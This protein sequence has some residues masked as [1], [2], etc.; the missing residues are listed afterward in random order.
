MIRSHYAD[1]DYHSHLLIQ[2]LHDIGRAT[3]ENNFLKQTTDCHVIS[4]VEETTT[5]WSRIDYNVS[6]DTNLIDSDAIDTDTI[7]YSDDDKTVGSN[8]SETQPIS[9]DIMIDRL[10]VIMMQRT[11]ADSKLSLLLLENEAL[12]N[13]YFQQL[14]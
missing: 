1:I 9:T 10:N 5:H 4:D 13:Y 8:G 14:S 7:V 2:T 6:E 3:I 12:T 11:T